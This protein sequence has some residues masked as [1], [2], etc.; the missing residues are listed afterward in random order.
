MGL[1]LGHALANLATTEQWLCHPLLTLLRKATSLGS[2]SA[3]GRL[4]WWKVC[5]F[6]H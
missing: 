1:K 4:F 3:T 5:P 2:W 6:G